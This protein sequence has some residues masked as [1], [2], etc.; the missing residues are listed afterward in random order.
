MRNPYFDDFAIE[1]P[2]RDEREDERVYCHN[3]NCECYLG[4]REELGPEHLF[5]GWWWCLEHADEMRRYQ[6]SPDAMDQVRR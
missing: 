2:D 5:N 1:F 4:L 3:P 6:G